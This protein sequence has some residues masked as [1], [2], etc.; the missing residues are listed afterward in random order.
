M[1]KIRV[2]VLAHSCRV[3]G[4]LVGTTDLVRAL[5]KVAPDERCLLICSGGCGLERLDMA[6]GN[7]R[8][9][10]EGSHSPLQRMRFETLTLPKIIDRYTPQVILNLNNEGIAKQGAPQVLLFRNAY[11]LYN[12]KHFPNMSVKASL[13]LAL[14]RA[15]VRRALPSTPLVFTQTPVMKQRFA[16]CFRYPESHIEVQPYPAPSDMKPT[17]GLGRPSVFDQRS[18]G[19]YILVL[20]RYMAH[21]N[22][23]V[24]I[25][26]CRRYG[27]QIREQGIRFITTVGPADY[28]AAKSFLKVIC[29]DHLQ[30]VILNVGS[31]SREDVLRYY[32]HSSLLWMPT[33]I[34]SLPL[35]YLEA[36]SMGV[37]ILA[38]DI[39]FAQ[40][41]CGEAAAFYDP[42]D[43][44]SIF[45][46]IMSLRNDRALRLRLIERGRT[47]LLDSGRF[48]ENWEEVAVAVM[49]GL[50]R[51][52]RQN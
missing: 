2:V 50:K 11:P 46:G 28:P 27:H 3:G 23:K 18:D 51:V 52:A 9:V 41:I 1:A 13:R 49:A 21:R 47:A 31:L 35:P 25:P 38:P 42:W 36:M 17:V 29:Q 48:A 32:S 14:L 5:E 30:D 24:L 15:R 19:F 40:Y 12:R 39:D 7:G 45:R 16:R 22:P 43:I 37:P 20:T 26:L 4:A 10:Y 44:D 8:F 6:S 34:E 33:L